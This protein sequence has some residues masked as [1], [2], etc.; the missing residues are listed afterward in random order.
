[1]ENE[2]WKDIPG[3]A[4]IYQVSSYGNVRS[5]ER[6]YTIC[7]KTII[8]TKRQNISK[9]ILGKRHTAGGYIWKKGG[10]K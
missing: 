9:V 5:L 2:I 8:S 10:S 7:S 6:P 4:G 3:Y 1:M